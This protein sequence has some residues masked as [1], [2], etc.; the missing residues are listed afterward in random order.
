LN[1]VPEKYFHRIEYLN[2]E[3]CNQIED[4]LLVELFQRKKTVTIYNYYG[5]IVDE[6]E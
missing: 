1:D 6:D 5:S 3:H 2:C 4:Q